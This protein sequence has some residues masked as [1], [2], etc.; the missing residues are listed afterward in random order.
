MQPKPRITRRGFMRTT[1]AFGG[2]MLL[3][4]LPSGRRCR[5]AQAAA[6]NVPADGYL[7]QLQTSGAW[8]HYPGHPGLE[9]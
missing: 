8:Y 2:T 9:E 5:S 7:A 4:A 3:N 6:S 1:A